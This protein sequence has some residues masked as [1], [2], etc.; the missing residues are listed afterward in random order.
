MKTLLLLA[1]LSSTVGCSVM[2]KR[3]VA[4]DPEGRPNYQ[5]VL[6]AKGCTKHDYSV[7]SHGTVY[8]DLDTEYYYACMQKLGYK[9]KTETR[10]VETSYN[11]LSFSFWTGEE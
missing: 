11:P 3:I 6:D 8:K 4:E 9:F 10:K 5:Y 7:G 2:G 1:L